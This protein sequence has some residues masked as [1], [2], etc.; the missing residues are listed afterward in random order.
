MRGACKGNDEEEYQNHRE[1]SHRKKEG[2]QQDGDGHRNLHRE[3]PPTLASEYVDKRTPERFDEPWQADDGGHQT[4]GA[5][6][7]PHVLED[8][9]RY[10]VDDEV[11]KALCEIEGRDPQP[12]PRLFDFDFIHI[13]S[14]SVVYSHHGNLRKLA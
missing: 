5:V 14:V 2:D 12:W 4:E 11:R 9:Q 10:G 7:Q 8:R 1:G 13:Y 3:N 6:V